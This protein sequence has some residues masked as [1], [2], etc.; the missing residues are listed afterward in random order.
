MVKINAYYIFILLGLFSCQNEQVAEPEIE[1]MRGEIAS[2]IVDEST[3]IEDIND[4]HEWSVYQG[5]IGTY[6]QQVVIE[7]GI[8]ENEVT[9]R[10]FYARHQ[11]FLSL[12]GTFDSL[13]KEFNLIETYRGKTTGQIRCIIDDKGNLDGTWSKS[14]ESEPEPFKATKLSSG[15]DDKDR[16]NVEFLKYD[17][18]HEVQI[19][20]GV[21]NESNREFVVD[22][23]MIS[24][25]DASH[26]SFH[27][28]I[29]GGN[30]HTGS[31]DGIGSMSTADSAEFVAPQSGCILGFVFEGDSLSV[32][33]KEDCSYYRGMRAH[34]TN[35]LGKIEKGLAF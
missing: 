25:I 1:S 12:E 10:Y 19:Y 29:I 3:D 7:I 35:K 26:F 14:E 16:L 23:L 4:D 24:K 34:F 17:N 32:I 6:E 9:G 30:R 8:V 13:T 15:D 2:D 22:E 31:I 21:S 20:S 33:E 28:S 18:R 5:R 11:N 27:Y